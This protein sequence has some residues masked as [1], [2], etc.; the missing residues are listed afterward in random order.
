M[1]YVKPV[2]DLIKSLLASSAGKARV[3]IGV[4]MS[5][6][7]DCALQI[8]NS[9]AKGLVGGGITGSKLAQAVQMAEG[10]PSLT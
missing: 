2:G 3:H 10:M 7:S 8:L 5:L 6:T 9:G 4:L 1:A